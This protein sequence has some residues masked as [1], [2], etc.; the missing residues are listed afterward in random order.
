[1]GY[2]HKQL[3]LFD[4][5]E[6]YLN[7]KNGDFPKGSYFLEGAV[8]FLKLG[9]DLFLQVKAALGIYIYV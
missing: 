5:N 4:I 6:F 1:M 3:G 9:S 8:L 2:V 7:P